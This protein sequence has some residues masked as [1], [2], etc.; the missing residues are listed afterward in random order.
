MTVKE[1]IEELQKLP[2]TSQNLDVVVKDLRDDIPYQDSEFP[3]I[4]FVAERTVARMPVIELE[5]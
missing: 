5:Y 1:L 3:I 2:I 4:R